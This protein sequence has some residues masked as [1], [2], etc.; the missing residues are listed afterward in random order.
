MR[1][2]FRVDSSTI[3]GSGHLMRCLTLANELKNQDHKV[4]FICGEL[5][6]NLVG[7]IKHNVLV[8]PKDDNFKA[9][10]MYLSWLGS[11]QEEDAK[12]TVKVIPKK[13]DY[14]IVD[15][16]SLDS[17]W[18]QKLRPHVRRIM[19]IDDLA[20][21]KF[22]CDILLD[23]NLNS[24]VESYRNKVPHSCKI[25][26]GNDYALLRPEFSLTRGKALEK[27]KNTK[28]IRSILVS[29]GGSD[30]NNISYDILQ[31]LD[32]NYNTTVVLGKNSPH[33]VMIEDYAKGKNIEVVINA[34]NMSKLMLKADLAIGAGGSTSW[35]RCCLGLPTLLFVTAENQR[36]IA[37]NLD[38]LGAV[39]LVKNLKDDLQAIT[40]NVDL[41]HAISKSASTICDGIGVKRVVK[42]LE[43]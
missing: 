39:I 43:D 41:W 18:H 27:R 30:I 11:T 23:Q 20:N 10:D 2:V 24:K 31:D 26:L 29:M 34:R 35:E 22:D 3:M 7:L 19:V 9:N 13:I 33:N 32:C 25:F 40:N 6:G 28:E 21:R 15:S 14:L 37:K 4:V 16:Y 12:Q 38:Q 36:A 17:E 5:Q 42:F 8:L 1:F